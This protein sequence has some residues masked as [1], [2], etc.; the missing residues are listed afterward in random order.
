MNPF[1]TNQGFN[2]QNGQMNS[3]GEPQ[4]SVIPRPNPQPSAFEMWASQQRGGVQPTPPMHPG[5][6]PPFVGKFI[7]NPTEIVPN[8]IPLDGRMALFPFRDCSAIIAKAWNS[9]GSITT[10][11]YIVDPSQFQ[12]TTPEPSG[13]EIA[14]ILS[15]LDK[16][17]QNIATKT[18]K[19]KATNVD[20]E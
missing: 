10:V 20:E 2:A 5:M 1:D 6:M 8:D 7:A 19:R 18:T 9:N 15:R 14:E 12:T 4:S 17:E 11:R 3:F 16:L 13:N